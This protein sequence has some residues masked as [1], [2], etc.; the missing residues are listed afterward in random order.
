MAGFWGRRKREQQDVADADANLAREADIALV[1]ADERL[2]V[3][4]DEMVFAEA[5]LGEEATAPLREAIAA[6]R[7]HLGEAFHLKQLNHDEIPDTPEEVRTRNAR[8]VQLCEWAQDLLDD[9]VS[10]LSEAI[11]RARRAPE[12]LAGIRADVATLRERIAPARAV[13][14]RVSSRYHPDALNRVSGNADETGGRT[15]RV[16]R[17]RG[18][19]RRAPARCRR[20]RS[21]EHRARDRDRSGT[22]RAHPARRGRRLRGRG[23]SG[24][25]DPRRRRRRLA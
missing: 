12:I 1:G 19:C 24:A 21:R 14:E 18:G 23:A 3:T 6:V 13:I 8:I 9:R 10:A 16:R 7:H 15:P 11:E 25:V 5:E 4:S 17:A 20:A 2:R 22:P